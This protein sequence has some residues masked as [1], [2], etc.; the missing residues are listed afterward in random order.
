MIGE[1]ILS[2]MKRVLPALAY[3]LWTASSLGQGALGEHLSRDSD[4]GRKWMYLSFL[5]MKQSGLLVGEPSFL[6]RGYRPPSRYELAVCVHATYAHLHGL[7]QEAQEISSQAA[8]QKSALDLLAVRRFAFDLRVLSREFEAELKSLGVDVPGLLKDLDGL[9]TG[10]E[11]LASRVFGSANIELAPSF[12]G[13]RLSERESRLRIAAEIYSSL[14]Q[15]SHVDV[16]YQ[17][18]LSEAKQFPSDIA[19]LLDRY[20]AE[21]SQLGLTKTLRQDW[22]AKYK[23]RLPEWTRRRAMWQAASKPNP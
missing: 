5:P 12:P 2:Y 9:P 11:K 21:L 4:P 7:L 16:S 10:I 23:D 1:R 17:T 18:D 15:S 13:A 3:L 14:E 6:G 8:R 22:L 19:I 20:A